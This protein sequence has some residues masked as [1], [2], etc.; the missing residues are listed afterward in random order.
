MKKGEQDL[1]V[2]LSRQAVELLEEARYLTG[3]YCYVFTS[4]RTTLRPIVACT[5]T[6][7]MRRMGITKEQ[8][9]AHGFRAT[10]RNIM[11]ERLEMRVDIVEHQ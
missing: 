2:P 8:A 11:D 5:L 9:T 6:A 3:N 4:P 7:A 10:A 1:Y